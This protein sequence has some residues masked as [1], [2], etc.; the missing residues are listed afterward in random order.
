[1]S[2]VGVGNFCKYTKRD[3]TLCEFFDQ[4]YVNHWAYFKG[5]LCEDSATMSQFFTAPTDKHLEIKTNKVWVQMQ[6]YDKAFLTAVRTDFVRGIVSTYCEQFKIKLDYDEK[7]TVKVNHGVITLEMKVV[8]LKSFIKDTDVLRLYLIEKAKIPTLPSKASSKQT[9]EEANKASKNLPVYSNWLALQIYNVSMARDEIDD[10]LVERFQYLLRNDEI[11]KSAKLSDY[12]KTYTALLSTFLDHFLF[13]SYRCGCCLHQV[14]LANTNG[15]SPDFYVAKLNDSG[16]PAG[17]VLLADYKKTGGYDDA[18]TESVS[19]SI[20][21]LK[22]DEFCSLL[23]LPCSQSKICL[24]LHTT[25]NK[26]MGIIEIC[27]TD[28]ND[29]ELL[30]RLLYALHFGVHEFINNMQRMTKSLPVFEPL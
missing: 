6:G 23:S 16:L 15:E 18:Y 19:Y 24:Q 1:V 3:K 14:A 17:A 8:A 12:E 4:Y 13:D 28:I 27:E 5:T 7:L 20:K 10:N 11:C 21:V 9:R 29:K 22:E 26:K 25:I 2:V 30:K